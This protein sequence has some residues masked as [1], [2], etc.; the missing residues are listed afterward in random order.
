MHHLSPDLMEKVMYERLNALHRASS[1]RWG[2][3]VKRLWH[4]LLASQAMARQRARLAL[5]DDHLLHDIGISREEA[6]AE[7]E[8]STWDAPA[9]W[10]ARKNDS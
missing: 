6:H 1:P 9:S 4:G 2:N 7:S 3:P 8:R 5:L 10:F